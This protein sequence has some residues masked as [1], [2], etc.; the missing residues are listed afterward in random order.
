MAGAMA[1]ALDLELRSHFDKTLDGYMTAVW[2]K[3]GKHEIPYT[4]AG[5][6]DVLGSF[7]GDKKFAETWFDHYINGHEPIDYTT[8]LAP[9]GFLLRP[10]EE[11]QQTH[12]SANTRSFTEKEGLLIGNNTVRGT[13]VYDAGLDVDDKIL[14]IDNQ[15]IRT[16]ADLNNVLARLHPGVAVEIRY[17]HRNEEK[18]G[19]IT[20]GENAAVSVVT[21]EQAGKP[22]TPAILQFRKSWLGAKP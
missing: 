13:P 16:L 2:K 1:L 4:V 6:Q 7:T 19:N 5:L 20:P 21:F 17:L 3:F 9:A 10:A 8:L 11:G 18:K 12:G 15:D 22:V 14:S